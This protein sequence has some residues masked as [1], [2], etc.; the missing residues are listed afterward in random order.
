MFGV[1]RVKCA[2][3][4]ESFWKRSVKVLHFVVCVS[5]KLT[6]WAPTIFTTECR[7]R[8]EV[9][10]KPLLVFPGRAGPRRTSTL[11]PPAYVFVCMRD[12]FRLCSVFFPKVTTG[13]GRVLQIYR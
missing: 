7:E 11:F 13:D 8:D 4:F 1:L 9:R 6:D 5:V 10:M 2:N 12:L 3:F